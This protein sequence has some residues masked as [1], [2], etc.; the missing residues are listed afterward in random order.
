LED[1]LLPI[2]DADRQICFG[3]RIF[4]RG[5]SGCCIDVE[6]CQV[7]A[8][9]PDTDDWQALTLHPP[10]GTDAKGRQVRHGDIVRICTHSD[11]FLYVA[12]DGRLLASKRFARVDAKGLSEFIACTV[13]KQPLEHRKTIFL[14]STVTS[15]M[16]ETCDEDDLVRAR[17]NT[18]GKNQG[19]IVEK[20]LGHTSVKEPVSDIQITQPPAQDLVQGTPSKKRPDA[21]DEA[22]M[23][24]LAKVKRQRLNGGSTCEN[25]IIDVAQ[26]EVALQVAE[27]LQ[28]GAPKDSS[29]MPEKSASDEAT[30]MVI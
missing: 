20:D 6:E 13:D 18:F 7:S 27:R 22:D 1:E 28:D 24:T 26:K 23:M 2:S 11:R 16:I 9:W 14:K 3:D 10:L 4:M 12:P 5:F 15:C 21:L 29:C 19:W 17:S 8:Q 30:E 25:W